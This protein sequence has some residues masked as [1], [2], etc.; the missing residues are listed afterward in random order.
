M[1]WGAAIGSGIGLA[2][3]YAANKK[4][5]KAQEKA[6]GILEQNAQVV[7][8]M[9][10]MQMADIEQSRQETA[11]RVGQIGSSFV[12]MQKRIIKKLGP[13]LNP[14]KLPGL[15]TTSAGNAAPFTTGKSTFL[16]GY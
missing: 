10:Q 16:G 11:Q 7:G 5:K 13:A 2:S 12:N 15:G 6:Q 3:G 8:M 9:S 1:G 4:Q 14:N